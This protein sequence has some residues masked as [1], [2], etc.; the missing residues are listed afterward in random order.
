MAGQP[1]ESSRVATEFQLAN[2]G[3]L[4]IFHLPMD[5]FLV[6]KP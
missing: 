1:S 5:P 3:L 2:V 6:R 4:R